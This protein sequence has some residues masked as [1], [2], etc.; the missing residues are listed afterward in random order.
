MAVIVGT[1]AASTKQMVAAAEQ[2]LEQELL[3]RA[4][5]Q[6]A[7]PSA[8]NAV[9]RDLLPSDLGGSNDIASVSCS[10]SWGLIYSGTL[11]DKKLFGIYGYTV[12]VFYPD[13]MVS[14]T[15]MEPMGQRVTGLRFK[16]GAGGAKTKDIW[17]GH[18]KGLAKGEVIL[19]KAPIIY[20]KSETFNIEAIG[21]LGGENV[22]LLGK[23][24]EPKGE[25][26]SPE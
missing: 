3:R 17:I 4:V 20:N 8:A 24:V 21:E 19:T 11:T 16:L 18:G 25:T 2:Q 15:P 22:F 10:T 13:A 12:P 9:I 14:G 5:S 7:V 1:Y 26:I 6:R 23:I